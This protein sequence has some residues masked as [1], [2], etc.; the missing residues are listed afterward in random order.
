MEPDKFLEMYRLHVSK[1]VLFVFACIAISLFVILLNVS[2]GLYDISFM[3]SY[4]VLMDHLT[5]NLPSPDD[6]VGLRED[7]IIWDQRLPRA[8]AAMLVGAGLGICGAAMQSSLK[9]PLA[10]PYT[11]GISSGASLG[12]ALCVVMGISLFPAGPPELRIIIN[13]FVFSLIPAA[14]IIMVTRFHKSTPTTMI[15]TGVAVMYIFSATSSLI[16][17][18]ADPDDL[19]EVYNWN[20]GNLGAVSW[21][22][23]PFVLTAAVLGTA[24]LSLA[25]KRLNLLAMDDES[26]SSLGLNPRT[27]RT[28]ILIVVSLCTSMLVSFTG[29][30]GFV[31]LVAPHIVRLFLGSN[32]RYLL[33][34]AAMFGGMFLLLADSVAK[35]AGPT[36]LPVGVI[37]SLVGG[38]L[39]LYILLRQRKSQWR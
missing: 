22:E 2:I 29:T 32:N 11:T 10:D 28:L 18:I 8:L 14:V 34:A 12:V 21:E 35:V 15:L 30:I 39:F 7:M 1:K 33:P 38:P 3:D 9:N 20:L 37:T 25:W 27:T 13:A 4:R 16:M 23:L 31:G 5:G 26:A 6:Y 17:L 24:L 19:Q 36:D